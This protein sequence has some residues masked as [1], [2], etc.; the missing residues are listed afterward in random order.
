MYK[1]ETNQKTKGYEEILR[2]EISIEVMEEEL[3]LG[4]KKGDWGII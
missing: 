2:G 4:K 1:E 3:Q